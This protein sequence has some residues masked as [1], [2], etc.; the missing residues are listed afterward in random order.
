MMI[1]KLMLTIKKLMIMIKKLKMTM[2]ITMMAILLPKDSGRLP[3]YPLFIFP[4]IT[5]PLPL[6]QTDR[7]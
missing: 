4:S 1:K 2:K 5:E 6:V 3:S 7:F